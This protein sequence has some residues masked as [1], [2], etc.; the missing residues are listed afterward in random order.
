MLLGLL[1]AA[2]LAVLLQLNAVRSRRSDPFDFADDGTIRLRCWVVVETQ[3]ALASRPIL[4][5]PAPRRQAAPLRFVGEMQML[6]CSPA[7]RPVVRT[8]PDAIIIRH[9]ILDALVAAEQISA[10]L[11]QSPPGGLAALPSHSTAATLH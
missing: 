5:L 10:A 4:A 3:P 7:R 11:W 1:A 9:D 6:R 2:M 8:P